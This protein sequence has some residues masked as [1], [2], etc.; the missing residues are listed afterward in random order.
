MIEK[1]RL[2][3]LCRIQGGYAFKSNQFQKKQYS[4]Y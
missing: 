2:G 1:V 3:E 4:Y